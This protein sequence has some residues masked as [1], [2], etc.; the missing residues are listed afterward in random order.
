[1]K[2]NKGFSL[3]ELLSVLVILAILLLLVSRLVVKNIDESKKEISESEEKAIVNAAEKWSVNNSD[4]FDDTEA[5]KIQIGLDII[6]ILDASK[7]MNEEMAGIGKRMD[8]LITATNEALNIFHENANN[9]VGFVVFGGTFDGS[10]THITTASI[11]LKEDLKSITSVTPMKALT[12]DKK[13][14]SSGKITTNSNGDFAFSVDGKAIQVTNL[15]SG[16]YTMIGLQQAAQM[17]ANTSVEKGTRIPV[18]ILVT[19]GEPTTGSTLDE[20]NPFQMKNA[21]IGNGRTLCL[22]TSEWNTKEKSSKGYCSNF[23]INN[24]SSAD[25]YGADKATIKNSEMVYNVMRVAYL[26][27]QKAAE[28]YGSTAYFYTIGIG[29]LAPYANYMLSPSTDI[30]TLGVSV[31]TEPKGN[32][33]QNLRYYLEHKNV[34]EYKYNQIDEAFLNVANFDDL[35]DSLQRV[36]TRVTEAAKVTEVCVSIDDLYKGGYLS[37]KD[38]KLPSGS[39]TS[40]Y[41]LM[42]YNEATKQYSFNLAKTDEQKKSCENYYAGLKK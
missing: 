27:K 7:T 13:T 18:Y 17:F 41:V 42:S 36:A 19:D 31:S 4:L 16:T 34:N 20:S 10:Y 11:R 22:N 26:A 8:G 37:T 3:V 32:T 28:T 1:M 39:A 21:N 9:R 38:I 40:Q 5:S 14:S 35:R 2:K 23:I 29:N 12:Y 30:N 25:K 6:F 24:F 15:E 33:N